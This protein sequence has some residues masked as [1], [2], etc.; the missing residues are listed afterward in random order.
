MNPTIVLAHGAFAES[1]SW[2]KVVTL[3]QASGHHVISLAVP[4]RGVASDAAYLSDVVR[5][6]EGPVVLVG[7]SYGGAVISNADRTAGDIRGLVFVAAF[8]G[9]AD[10]SCAGLSGKFPG[11]TLGPTLTSV[12]LASGGKDLYIDQAKYRHQF[13]ADVSEQ[14]A[15]QMGVSQRPILESALA[16]PFGPD[17]LWKDTPSWFIWGE[18]DHNI[19]A[20]AHQFMAD[21]AGAR[22]AVQVRGASHVVGITHPEETAEVISH[23]AAAAG[24][25]AV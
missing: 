15:A 6:V 4:L 2:D 7:H 13:C 8:A 19:P 3:L 17:P 5:T 25:V 16:E 24:R 11:S 20:A 9:D 14:Q 22:D 23:A 18:L 1:S 12:D 21:R 10:E